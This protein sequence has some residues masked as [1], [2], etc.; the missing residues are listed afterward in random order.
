M[1]ELN[2]GIS[3]AIF[4]VRE[5]KEAKMNL[6][7]E[8]AKTA[9]DIYQKSGHIGG[10]EVQNWLEAERIVLMRHASQ[11]IEEPEGEEPLIEEER[12]RE[13]V[14]EKGLHY[15]GRTMK[16]EAVVIED[17]REPALA[18]N[19]DMAIRAERSRPLKTA[20]YKGRKTSPGTGIQKSTKG[21]GRGKNC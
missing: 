3:G 11:D 19:E 5:D 18:S 20:R 4:E 16:K 17:V 15:A 10:L 8:I 6:H 13:E 2:F 12:F 21:S 14:E 9:Y 7:D 1:Q